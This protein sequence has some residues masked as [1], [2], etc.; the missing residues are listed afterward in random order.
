MLEKIIITIPICDLK[1]EE[2]VYNV[3]GDLFSGK[4]EAA[5]TASRKAIPDYEHLD[6]CN[7]NKNK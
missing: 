2:E 3:G 4:S 1:E 7:E 6:Q 5:R